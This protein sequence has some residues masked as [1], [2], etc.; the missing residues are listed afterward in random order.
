MKCY[1]KF[2]NTGAG[3]ALLLLCW[4]GAASAQSDK[5]AYLSQGWSGADRTMF[6]TTS[7]GSQLLPYDWFLA[8]EQ[9]KLARTQ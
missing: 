7:Q 9:P 1:W 3:V 5:P 4:I 2:R 8:L 6:Y